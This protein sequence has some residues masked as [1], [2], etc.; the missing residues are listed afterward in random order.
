MWPQ[1]VRPNERG[2]NTHNMTKARTKQEQAEVDAIRNGQEQAPQ[3]VAE[4]REHPPLP[5]MAELIA[6]GPADHQ[7]QGQTYINLKEPGETFDGVFLRR[8]D[9][10]SE[11]TKYP[12]LVFAE[13]PSGA[14]RVMT[15]NWGVLDIIAKWEERE[16]D[17]ERHVARIVLTGVTEKKDGSTVKLY[18]G[19]LYKLPH[20]FRVQHHPQFNPEA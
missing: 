18:S 15:A 9:V 11:E 7:G 4:S 1:H 12:G 20:G 6:Q 16:I 14:I 13:Y 17:L 10:K 5:S 2:D 8:T 19:T 3:Q